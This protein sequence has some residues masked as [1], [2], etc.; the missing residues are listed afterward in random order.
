[1]KKQYALLLLLLSGFLIAV[2]QKK[3]TENI[4]IVTLDGL[5]WQEL[6][7][8][9]DSVLMT[10]TVY[11][12][13]PDRLRHRFWAATPEER[14]RRLFPFIW[15]V[16]DSL[17]Q[18]H[19]NRNLG[20]KVNVLNE[21]HYSYPGYNEMFTGFPND[22]TGRANTIEYPNKNVS[23]LE[24]LNGLPEYKNKVAVFT[25]WNAFHA[26]FAE[27]RSKIYVNAG[28]DSVKFESPVF[29]I[30]NEM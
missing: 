28:Y 2:A 25:S 11:T 14:R 19:G 23:V 26:I 30:L 29:K 7:T 27:K 24:F 15:S 1:M 8:G 3:Q 13:N 21:Y 20:S 17:G 4:I 18:I 22:T 6:F 10:N 9:A 16:I 5:R 12:R